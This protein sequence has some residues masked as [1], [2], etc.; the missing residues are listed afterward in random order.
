MKFSKLRVNRTL[1]TL[2]IL[3]FETKIF[4]LDGSSDDEYGPVAKAIR[5]DE[6]DIF[7]VGVGRARKNELV[8]IT[9]D[10]VIYEQ[11]SHSTASSILWSPNLSKMTK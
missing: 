4:I 1:R 10:E 6:V 3:K 5:D 11:Q 9:G 7:A 8:E 2:F